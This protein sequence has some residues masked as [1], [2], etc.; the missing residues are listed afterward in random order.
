M[1]AVRGMMVSL[2]VAGLLCSVLPAGAEEDAAT[3]YKKNKLTMVIGTS[4][5][6][7]SDVGARLFAKYWPEV[8]GGEMLIKN[9]PGAAG[10]VALNY[11]NACK[12]DGLTMNIMM[13]NGAYQMPY[14]QKNKAAKYDAREFKY[15]VGGF[16]E[17]WLLTAASKFKSLEEFKNTKGLRYGVNAPFCENTFAALPMIRGLGLDIKMV[18]GYKAQVEIDLAVGKGEIDFTLTPLSQGLRTVE[19]GMVAPPMLVIAAERTPVLPDVPCLAEVV[20][21]SPEDKRIFEEAM[22]LSAIIR[23]AAMRGDVPED[24][25]EFVRNAIAKMVELPAFQEDALKIL[26]L[27]ATPVLGKE[28][29][30]FLAGAFTLDYSNLIR[31]LEPYTK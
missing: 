8:T 27:G 18:T 4:P 7:A 12:P 15:I 14:F 5:G 9:M 28:L 29:D 31:Y 26:K 13:F 17:P 11:M 23:M 20:D 25:V 1:N 22:N 3:F 6:G 21:M 2:A 19:Q 10:I 30:D 24:R 16:C